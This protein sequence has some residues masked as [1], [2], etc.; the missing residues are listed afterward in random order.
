MR[1]TRLSRGKDRKVFQKTS[2]PH[3]G[4]TVRSVMRGGIRK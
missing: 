4:N 1:R 2:A 3:P